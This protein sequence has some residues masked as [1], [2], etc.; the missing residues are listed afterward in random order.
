M[1][2]TINNVCG[3]VMYEVEA[4]SFVKAVESKRANLLDANLRR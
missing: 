1:K 2:F 3:N 4:D